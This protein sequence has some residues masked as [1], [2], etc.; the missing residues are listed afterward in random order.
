MEDIRDAYHQAARR[1][2]PDSNKNPGA[3]ELFLQIQ[4]AYETLSNSKKRYEYDQTLPDDISN[5]PDILVNTIF[6]REVVPIISS[7]QLVYVLL[8]L[9]ALP[10]PEEFH[11]KRL[12]INIC[13]LLDTSTSMTGARLDAVKSSAANL[14][15]A[16]YPNDYFS[17]VTFNDYAE[18]IIP[19]AR[20]LDFGF[21]QSRISIIHTRGGTEIF[22]GLK[23]AMDEIEKNRERVFLNHIILITDG[24][25]YGDEHQ[26]LEL[27]EQ[28][29]QNGVTITCLGVGGDWN[30]QFLDDLAKRTGGSCA[31]ADQPGK[32]QQIMEEKF[33]LMRFT[34]ANNVSLEYTTPPNVELRYAFR[35]LPDASA[36]G[37]GERLNFGDIPLGR[38]LSVLMEFYIDGVEKETTTLTIADGL[39]HFN[40]PS[41]PI[42]RLSSR[43]TLTRPA[44]EDPQIAPPPQVLVRAMSRLSLYRLQEQAQLEIVAGDVEKA[45]RRLNNLA[46]NLLTSGEPVLAKTV[47]FELEKLLQGNSLSEEGKKQIKYG[48]RSLLKPSDM[49]QPG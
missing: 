28:A 1:L 46:A 26:C 13:M 35:L 48:T 6:S 9:L 40:I 25:T 31:Y 18:T 3:V 49:E 11:N 22:M 34:Y 32:I 2:H 20:G 38:S 5:L 21:I 4:E 42:P 23:A 39:L 8:D 24:R 47:R 17:I 15:N 12:P 16:L 14:I 43:L 37:V 7:P 33:G 10:E 27:A 36:V 19:A 30:D 41:R 45:T 44:A 29:N